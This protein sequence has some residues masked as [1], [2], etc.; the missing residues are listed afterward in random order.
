MLPNLIGNKPNWSELKKELKLIGREDVYLI[1]DSA[2]TLTETME[3]DVS[4]TSFYVSRYHRRWCG[5]Y[6]DV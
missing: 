2:D 6:G 4:T 3:T 5:W 1:E